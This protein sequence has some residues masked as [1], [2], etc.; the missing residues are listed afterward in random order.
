M[1][2]TGRFKDSK[3]ELILLHTTVNLF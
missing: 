1:R 2:F 3:N